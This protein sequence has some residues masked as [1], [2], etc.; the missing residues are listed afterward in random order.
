M[1]GCLCHSSKLTDIFYYV[2]SVP[3]IRIDLYHH[4]NQSPPPVLCPLFLF[5]ELI[6]NQLLNSLYH[7]QTRTQQPV[8][9]Q[10]NNQDYN[11]SEFN[12]SGHLALDDLASLG[13]QSLQNLYTNPPLTHNN[14]GQMFTQNYTANYDQFC[15]NTSTELNQNIANE[16]PHN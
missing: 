3:E 5:I 14:Q 13:Y 9:M 4:P 1:T 11:F 7:Q 15:N 16:T 12:A 8:A 2:L 6:R 10:S